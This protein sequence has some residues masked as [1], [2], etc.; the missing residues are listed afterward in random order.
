MLV[1]YAGKSNKFKLKLCVKQEVRKAQP[2][3]FKLFLDKTNSSFFGRWTKQSAFMN[4]II[5]L[6]IFYSVSSL[7]KQYYNMNIINMLTKKF[8]TAPHE[9]C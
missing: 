7:I 6:G 3:R 4:T 9:Q 1:S 8:S 2:G 5:H